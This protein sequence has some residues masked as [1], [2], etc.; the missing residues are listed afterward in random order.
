ML[1]LRNIILEM[2]AKGAD[3]TATM[4]R[5][6][7][8]VEALAPEVTCSV[9][10]VDR[11]GFLHPLS[12]P[13]L[14]AEFSAALDGLMIGP[15][16][17]SFGSAAYLRKPVVV[18][19]IACDPR[20]A[21][22]R[23][24]ALLLGFRACWSTPIYGELD[25]VIGTF[26]LYCRQPRTPSEE[27]KAIVEASTHLCSIALERHE[28]VLERERRASIDLLT[29]LGNRSAF[30]TALSLLPCDKPGTWA[31]LILDL[32][33]LKV[34][35]DGFGHHAGDLLIQ[36]AARRTEECA[37]P[38]RVFRIGGDEIAL[39]LRTPE[40]LHD[41]DGFAA[42]LL[43]CLT[44]PLDCNGHS[45]VPKA[46]IG[47]AI[48]DTGD[49]SPETV[50]QNADFALYHAKETG[51]GG[52]VRYW[53][54]IDTRIIHR[55]AAIRDVDAALRDHR[56]EA[57]YQ[58]IV[59]LDTR[60]IVAMEALCRLRMANGGLLAAAAFCEATADIHVASE[61]TQRMLEIVASD[62][63]HWR[64][65]SI[66]LEHIGINVSLAD[67][68][69]GQ[70]DTQI[71]SVLDGHDLPLE[72]LVIEVTESAYP[73]LRDKALLDAI[74]ALRQKGLRVA[75]DDFG[76]G[77]GLLMPLL[78][79]PVDMIKIDQ[80]LVD[81]LAPDGAGAAVIGGLLHTARELDIPVVAEGVESEA[82][83]A[84]LAQ[85]GCRLG[86]GYFYSQPLDYEA[87]T[88]LLLSPRNATVS[89][90][91]GGPGL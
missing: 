83:A 77:D 18:T 51:R 70:L 30:G 19:D 89:I 80:V 3:L 20:W 9:L 49:R 41:L 56:V 68:H 78:T 66:P 24:A 52:F 28:R 62:M 27:E 79:M 65:R 34:V 38:N 48:F 74:G 67:F 5:L 76:T 84:C 29:G 82:Q 87:A 42:R 25:R 36:A 54:G 91:V 50:R 81:H 57:H 32:D 14:P 26:A 40:A 90:G 33:N 2:I 69:G 4:D 13:G 15:N 7:L 75:I 63:R 45:V 10:S 31:L 37:A 22:F 47:G 64:E 21:D 39:I 61:L 72:H 85:L 86:Q 6:C 35:N 55:I 17:G 16:V 11:D 46:T 23:E 43:A 60:E 59:R 12:A 73:A 71:A 88:N 1:G 53:P 44:Q 8:E 58:P